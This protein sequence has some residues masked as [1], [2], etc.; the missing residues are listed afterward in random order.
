MNKLSTIELYK[1][2][3]HQCLM[4]NGLV[5]GEGVQSNQFLLIHQD[6]CLLIDPGGDLTFHPLKMSLAKY[7]SLSQ[8]EYIL[9]SHQDPDIIASI[10]GWLEIS[11]CKVAASRLWSR[12]LPHLASEFNRSTIAGSVFDRTIAIPDAGMKLPFGSSYI[13]CLPAHFMH[14][15]GNFS[16]YDPISKILFSGDIGASLGGSLIEVT[17]ENFETH[18][19]TMLGFHR[20]YM[21]SNKVCRL[22][23]NMVRSMD[24]EM[25]VPQHGSY[26]Q[27]E[28]IALFLDWLS[29]LQCGIDL[30]EQED[31]QPLKMD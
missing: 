2:H 18:K 26:F 5:E 8:L 31:F 17:A 28:S 22:W 30:L 27:G 6:H 23:A 13:H 24:V 19:A 14:S 15:P 12:F 11:P 10:D 29:E 4:F 9:A 20:R 1:D 3:Q 21:A 25:I 16:F 7:S